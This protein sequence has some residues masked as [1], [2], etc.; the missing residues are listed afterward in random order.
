MSKWSPIVV[1]SLVAMLGCVDTFVP[2][3]PTLLAIEVQGPPDGVAVIGE[4]GPFFATASFSDD[5]SRNVTSE[6]DWAS[7]DPSV[8]TVS[9]TGEGQAVSAGQA[10]VCATYQGLSGCVLVTVTATP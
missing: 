4:G 5:S 8:M 9:E 7:T 2:E 1:T 6:A 10:E 3:I